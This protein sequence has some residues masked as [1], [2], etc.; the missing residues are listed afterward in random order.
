MSAGK[1]DE[2]E[3][4]K[5][6]YGTLLR[7]LSEARLFLRTGHRVEDCVPSLSAGKQNIPWHPVLTTFFH[8]LATY[9]SISQM[10][11]MRRTMV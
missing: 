9:L 6:R 5:K 3:K 8:Y 11:E 2:E 1:K 10:E 7:I 4:A